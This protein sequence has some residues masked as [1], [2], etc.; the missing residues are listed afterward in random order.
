ML[1]K[2]AVEGEPLPWEPLLVTVTCSGKVVYTTQTDA[3]GNFGIVNVIL[4]GAL[5]KQGDSERQMET[6][7]EGC[8]VQGVVPGFHSS[9]IALT[10]HNLRDQPDLGTITISRAGRD[11]ATTLSRTTDTAS[12][13][14]IKS[15][16]KA[17]SRMIERDSDGAEKELEKTVQ[18]DPHFAEAWLQLGKLQEVSE[19]QAARESFSKAL[20]A[21]PNYVLPYEQLAVLAAQSSNWQEVLDNTNRVIQLYPEGT[22][23]VWYMNALANYQLGKPD[24]AEAGA[25]KSLALDPRHSVL[26]T[27]QLLAV[28]LAGKGDF[29]GALDHLRN[30]LKYVP[31]GPNADLLKQQIAQLEQHVAAK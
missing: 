5:G 21:D 30:S 20:A 2:L 3:K 16:E 13:K 15:F 23:E 25:Q 27:E 17:R 6:H 9:T 19:P 28:I 12:P 1:G 18:I 8:L 29:S 11:A 10:E 31:P 4:S 26:N 7:L 14:A 24:A 22:P